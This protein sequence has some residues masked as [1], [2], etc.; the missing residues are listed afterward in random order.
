[1]YSFDM[2]QIFFCH[3]IL[4]GGEKCANRAFVNL[5]SSIF[6]ILILQHLAFWHAK[7]TIDVDARFCVYPLL[8]MSNRSKK[9]I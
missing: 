5:L 9:K 6:Y 3:W 4:Q 2:L 7:F 1:M 8:Q